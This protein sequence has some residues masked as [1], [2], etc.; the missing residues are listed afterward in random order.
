MKLST[1]FGITMLAL[2]ACLASVGCGAPTTPA[3]P[4]PNQPSTPNSPAATPAPAADPGPP[5]P[6]DW[7]VSRLPVEPAHLNL[8]LDTSD[9]YAQRVANGPV[10]QTLLDR[11]NVTLELIPVL[12]ESYEIAPDH[13]TYTFKIR[14]DAM[15][16][17]GVP[18]TAKD[19]KFS[20]D[21]I[22]NPANE[23]ADLR[24]YFQDIDKAELLDDYTIKFTC[25]RVYF[26][27]LESIGSLP[28]YPEHIYSQ[29]TFNTHSNN[30]AP[31][32]SGPYLFD[33]WETNQQIVLKRNPNYWN[34]EKAPYID[35]VVWKVITDDDISLQALERKDLDVM[36]LLPRQWVNQGKS[37]QFEAMFDKYTTWSRPGYL[38]NMSYIAWNLRKPQFEDKRVRQALT[39]LLDRETILETIFY[40]LGQVVSGPEISTV[41]EYD[42]SIQPWPFDPER[43]KQLL[44]E[45]G[46]TDTDKDGILDKDGKPFTFEFMFPSG[47]QETEQMITVYQEELKRAGIEMKILQREWATFLENVT[48]RAFDAI[49]LSWAIP[50]DSD[51]YQV[52]HSSQTEKGSN[53]PGFANAEVDKLLEDIRLEFDRSKRIPMFHRFH[54]ILHDEQPYTFLFNFQSLYAVDK[55]YRNV[56]MYPLGFDLREWWT[57]L[58]Q[59]RY[60]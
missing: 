22:M 48:K 17:D 54:A 31:I 38:G 16:S 9:A 4:T 35:R 49:T 47:S 12:A 14:K 45:A 26:K 53:Y 2:A 52:W 58:A 21:T 37:P 40:G 42:K 28:V 27:H 3:E 32:G 59:Q 11:D 13:L 56:T 1:P 51:P 18:V 55:R 10:F 15:F 39:M 33:S 46:W 5:V 41:A 34:K 7:I 24:N 44:A 29:G 30:R 43:A 36:A 25:K 8:L 23:T 20:L 57:P 60:K 19:V 6:G 50:V